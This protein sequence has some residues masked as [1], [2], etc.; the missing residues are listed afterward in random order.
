MKDVQKELVRNLLSAS[1][2]YGR[3]GLAIFR[4]KAGLDKNNQAAIGNLAIATELLLKTYIAKLNLQ[5]LL[6]DVP[7]ELKCAL[8]A[9]EALPSSFKK[10]PHKIELRSSGFKSIEL[11]EAISVFSVFFP[12][13]KKRFGA[14]LRFLSRYR[15]LCVHAGLPDFR[16][17]EVQRTVY[18][19]LSLFNHL[20]E[21]ESELFKYQNLGDKEENEK[22]LRQ[23]DEERLSRV[24]A[25]IES[26]R[27]K[28]KHIEST[29]SASVDAWEVC[30]IEC[31]ICKS[32]GLMF[33][34]T[35][36][37]SDYDD[38]DMPAFD[39]TFFGYSFECEECGLKLED[40]D[41]LQMAGIDP[42]VDRSS[43]S[44]RWAREYYE[45]YH[46]Y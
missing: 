11:D 9:P 32:D 21:H 30:V 16:E 8:S 42:I 10:A 45:D 12:D 40:Y 43:E 38:D 44:D 37:D 5:L 6:K 25:A 7:I 26:A 20:K 19:Y 23:F 14:H 34:D 24:H 13:I 4:G 17:Y 22:F 31:P 29:S 41:E 2:G 28:A 18:L 27:E 3:A 39:L 35:Q 36:A 15:N 33:G 1:I 46:D